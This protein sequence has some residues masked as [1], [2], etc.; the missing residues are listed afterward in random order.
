MNFTHNKNG[1]FFFNNF[2]IESMVRGLYG[3]NFVV[4]YNDIT[5]SANIIRAEIRPMINKNS[6]QQYIYFMSKSGHKSNIFQ[7][8]RL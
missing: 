5:A 3:R 6:L 1:A 2:L 8:N 4:N 7:I